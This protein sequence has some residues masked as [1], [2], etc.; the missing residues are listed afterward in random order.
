VP[1]SFV[2]NN[3]NTSHGRYCYYVVM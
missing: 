1:K 3:V 2:E